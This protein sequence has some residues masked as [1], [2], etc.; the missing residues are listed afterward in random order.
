VLPNILP[1]LLH[2]NIRPGS[3]E[4]QFTRP[5]ATRL[6]SRCRLQT[7]FRCEPLTV[8][9]A[10]GLRPPSSLLLLV[11]KHVKKRP[12]KAERDDDQ[13]QQPDAEVDNSLQPMMFCSYGC[14]KS[15]NDFS[16]FVEPIIRFG[17]GIGIWDFVN[18]SSQL[19]IQNPKSEIPNPSMS[20]SVLDSVLEERS[21]TGTSG[22]FIS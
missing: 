21:I 13:K 9:I 18:W 15:T 10:I 6:Q 22:R 1:L 7:R 14:S 16:C 3:S 17:F 2:P 5:F 19:R 20:V 8:A 11:F 12:H 4:F